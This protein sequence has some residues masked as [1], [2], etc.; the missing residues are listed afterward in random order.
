MTL[1]SSKPQNAPG[2]CVQLITEFQF[3]LL[4]LNLH[5]ENAGTL[6]TRSTNERKCI[7]CLSE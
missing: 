6:Q 2:E 4:Q 1:F 7:L 3:K 5:S